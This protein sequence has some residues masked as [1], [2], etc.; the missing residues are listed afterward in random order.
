MY[1]TFLEVNLK[2]DFRPTEN[3]FRKYES[4]FSSSLAHIQKPLSFSTN[5]SGFGNYTLIFEAYF[6]E[7]SLTRFVKKIIKNR[8]GGGPTQHIYGIMTHKKSNTLR[9]LVGCSL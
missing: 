5:P 9:K 2:F 7:F 3:L 4:G 8:L 1:I 6:S